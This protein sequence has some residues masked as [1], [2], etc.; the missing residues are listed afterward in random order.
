MQVQQ[1]QTQAEQSGV[2]PPQ[3]IARFVERMS[4]LPGV[5]EVIEDR[6]EDVALLGDADD[7]LDI[8]DAL[9]HPPDCEERMVVLPRHVVVGGLCYDRD[10]PDPFE[11][12][13]ANGA[14]HYRNRSGYRPDEFYWAFGFTAEGERDLE[15]EEV[16]EEWVALLRQTVTINRPLL[17]FLS[18]LLKEQGKACGVADVG[19]HLADAVLRS[20][21][22]DAIDRFAEIFLGVEY[23]DCLHETWQ[24]MLEPVARVLSD[25]GRDAAWE[26]ACR[27]GQVGNPLAV[28]LNVYETYAVNYRMSGDGVDSQAV[29]VPCENAE[30]NLLWGALADA[31]I[32]VRVQPAPDAPQ[33]PG[34]HRL[35][36][37]VDGGLTWFGGYARELAALRAARQQSGKE[38]LVG[39]LMSKRAEQYCRAVLEEVNAINGGDVYGVVVATICR[40]TGECLDES[41]CWGYVG[42]DC[43]VDEME[44]VVAYFV[45]RLVSAD[46]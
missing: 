26:S 1:V 29:W 23:F 7:V 27:K 19:D 3:P 21:S 16:I 5:E 14:I 43:A 31:G 28:G 2:A 20:G 36:L 30:A 46:H 45:E 18:R 13:S 40:E 6:I 33:A 24:A 9:P 38:R 22:R 32:D 35:C 17:G 10:P 15:A 39:R 37:S 25:E 12:E 41:S 4:A 11:K 44:A 42:R 8:G 34:R